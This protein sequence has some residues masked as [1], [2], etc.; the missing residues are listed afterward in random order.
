MRFGASFKEKQLA[1]YAGCYFG[2]ASL[3]KT[4][5]QLAEEKPNIKAHLIM[6]EEGGYM[7]GGDFYEEFMASEM[8]MVE[9]FMQSKGFQVRAADVSRAASAVRGCR[10]VLS[11]VPLTSA[12]SNSYPNM[13]TLS[14]TLASC[15]CHPQSPAFFWICYSADTG[16]G[17]GSGDHVTT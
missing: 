17:D 10:C 13:S 1:K 6:S 4:L 3:K 16:G 15:L 14:S 9:T 5:Y 8:A 7:A 12:L 11:G 2:Y